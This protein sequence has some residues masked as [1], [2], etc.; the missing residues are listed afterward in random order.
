MIDTL[1]LQD[2]TGGRPEAKAAFA[3]LE[4]MGR[5]GR[6]GGAATVIW[7]CLEAASFVTGHALAV[8]GGWLAQQLSSPLPSAPRRTGTNMALQDPNILSMVGLGTL[9][10]TPTNPLQPRLVDAVHLPWAFRAERGF[11]WHRFYLFRRV[12]KPGRGRCLSQP[13]SQLPPGPLN[14]QV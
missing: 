4:P 13:M 1:M 8:D 10:D 14:S 11:R 2:L 5:L 9:H 7:L 3:A 12:A 6:L